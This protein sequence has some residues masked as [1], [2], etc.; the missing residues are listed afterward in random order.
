MIKRFPIAGL[1]L[2]T[3]FMLLLVS[4]GQALAA[5]FETLYIIPFNK[6][7]APEVAT[8]ALFDAMVERLFELGE[9]RGIQVTIVK[10]ELT[11]ADADWFA[12]EHYLIGEVT[13]YKEDKG[14]CYTELELTGQAQLHLPG[15]EKKPIVELSDESFFNHDISPLLEAQTE[16]SD[17]LGKKMAEQLLL[18]IDTN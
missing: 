13:G 14:C 7:V 10:Q 12:G 3:V 2:A 5:S 18:Q 6:G 1:V 4:P 16:L 9:Q 15:G 11:D 17:R 8:T